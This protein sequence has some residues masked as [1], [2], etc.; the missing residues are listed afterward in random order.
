MLSFVVGVCCS[1][2]LLML[3]SL[4]LFVVVGVGSVLF[5]VLVLF[6]GGAVAVC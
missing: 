6:V 1:L 4:L 3:P 2:L 5:C